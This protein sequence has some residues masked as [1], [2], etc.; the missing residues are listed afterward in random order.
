[1]FLLFADLILPRTW[2]RDQFETVDEKSTGNDPPDGES[3]I[4]RDPE[5]I[6]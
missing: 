3:R 6:V 4:C 2:D 1:M 5:G